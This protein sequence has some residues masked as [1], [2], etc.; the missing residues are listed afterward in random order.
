MEKITTADELRTAISRLEKNQEIQGQLLK[1]HFLVAC[2]SLRPSNIIR[3]S[4]AELYSSADFK[5]IIIAAVTGLATYY[6]ANKSIFLSSHN[7]F[8]RLL[9]SLLQ[10]GISKVATNH[11]KDIKSIGQVLFQRIFR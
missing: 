3:N 2:E 7:I 5:G 4:I 1:D 11:S 10:L 9:G 6:F 8:K